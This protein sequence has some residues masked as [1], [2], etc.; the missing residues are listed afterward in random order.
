MSYEDFVE[1]ISNLDPNYSIGIHG[2][3]GAG[4]HLEKIPSILS[5]GLRLKGWGGILSNVAMFGQIKDLTERDYKELYDYTYGADN[6]GNIINI[7]FAFP[8]TYT[9]EEGREFYLGNF[10]KVSGYAKGQAEAGDHNPLNKISEMQE[11]IPKEFILGYSVM[12]M[13][14]DNFSFYKNPNFYPYLD[15]FDKQFEQLLDKNNVLDTATATKKLGL[16]KGIQ[17]ML[18]NEFTANLINFIETRLKKEKEL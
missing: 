6:E 5:Q 14:T 2:V 3:T 11:V 16:L 17:D 10:P 7:F 8:E 15:G 13:E 18:G 9:T 4:N 12:K 1:Y